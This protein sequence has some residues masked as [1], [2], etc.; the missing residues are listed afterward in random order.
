M[1]ST[2]TLQSSAEICNATDQ[3]SFTFER[4]EETVIL[5]EESFRFEAIHTHAQSFNIRTLAR[6]G[7]SSMHAKRTKSPLAKLT[8]GSV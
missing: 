5:Q 1:H 2:P 7:G 6:K 3:E 4:E 8:P